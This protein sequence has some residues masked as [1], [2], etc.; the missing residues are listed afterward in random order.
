MNTLNQTYNF[1]LLPGLDGTG[2]SYTWLWREMMASGV[3]PDNVYIIPY[4]KNFYYD[5]LVEKIRPIIFNSEL[6]VFIIA[7]SFAG[8]LALSL[9]T[10][11]TTKIKKLVISGSFGIRPDCQLVTSFGMELFK[12]YPKSLT[13]LNNI[14]HFIL[15]NILM[16][17]FSNPELKNVMSEIYS[18]SNPDIIDKR[19]N[20]IV[21]LPSKWKD[22][23]PKPINQ[24]TLIL[25]P[26]KDRLISSNNSN[27]LHD[28]LPNS[29][30]VELNAPHFLLQTHAVE[31]WKNIFKFS[32]TDI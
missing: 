2:Q 20:E 12:L 15:N 1:I 27:I 17:N 18:S 24:S 32:Q 13:P 26:L 6:P 25:K 9:A 29:F 5:D 19:I 23:W 7:E 4:Y 11:Y 16:N 31:A 28:N 3:A 21:K 30:I 14:P 8:P 22:K 10:E